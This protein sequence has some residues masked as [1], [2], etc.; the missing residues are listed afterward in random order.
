MNTTWLLCNSSKHFL[1][2]SSLPFTLRAFYCL[3]TT[4]TSSSCDGVKLCFKCK[5]VPHCRGIKTSKYSNFRRKSKFCRFF[6]LGIKNNLKLGQRKREESR[7]VSSP[8]CSPVMKT[9]VSGCVAPNQARMTTTLSSASTKNI[10][11][12][13]LTAHYCQRLIS[14]LKVEEKEVKELEGWTAYTVISENQIL[15]CLII[16]I[17]SESLWI[18]HSIVLHNV[19]FNLSVE[20]ESFLLSN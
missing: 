9:Y 19:S 16:L 3:E 5:K 8:Y 12:W 18:I 1:A 4:G 14:L 7:C 6:V 15:M 11:V 20:M 10:S 17:P 2:F 13:V